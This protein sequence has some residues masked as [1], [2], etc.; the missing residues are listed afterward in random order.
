MHTELK[1][2]AFFSQT[3]V[4]DLESAEIGFQDKDSS[5][6]IQSAYRLWR[7]AGSTAVLLIHSHSLG[8][9]TVN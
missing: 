4:L 1:P 9:S 7:S 6:E 2:G 3:W 5:V 8:G